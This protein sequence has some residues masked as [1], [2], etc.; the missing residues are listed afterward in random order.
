[1]RFLTLAAFAGL[2]L[3]G[4]V[5]ASA[6]SAGD[7]PFQVAQNVR[8]ETREGGYR[9][10]D[11]TVVRVE[12]GARPMRPHARMRMMRPERCR[13]IITKRQTPR[14]MVTVRERRCR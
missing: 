10:R 1:M 14:G 2:T 7:A 12:R 5:P 3:L 11:R 8:V 6:Q 4:A 9:D 13:V